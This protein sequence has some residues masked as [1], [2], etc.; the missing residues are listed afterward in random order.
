[1]SCMH[2]HSKPPFHIKK[3]FDKYGKVDAS[4]IQ[5]MNEGELLVHLSLFDRVVKKCHFLKQKKKGDG[6]FSFCKVYIYLLT[7]L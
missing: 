1:M 2:I 5:V 6:N 4:V 7:L 3:I